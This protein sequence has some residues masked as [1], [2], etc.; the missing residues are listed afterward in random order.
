MKQGLFKVVE[1]VVDYSTYQLVT[2]STLVTG[3]GQQYFL[4]KF[5]AYE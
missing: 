5:S 1:S 3:K 2:K 4:N